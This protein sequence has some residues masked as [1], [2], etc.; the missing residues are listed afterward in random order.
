[1]VAAL[2]VL[3]DQNL[4]SE[5]GQIAQYPGVCRRLGALFFGGFFVAQSQRLTR[6]PSR[7]GFERVALIDR[8]D[9]ALISVFVDG[10]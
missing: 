6:F 5:D 10:F 4:Q 2:R 8:G 7:A 9:L 1:M 3:Q